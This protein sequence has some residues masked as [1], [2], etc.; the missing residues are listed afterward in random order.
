MAVAIPAALPERPFHWRDALRQWRRIQ[1]AH[2]QASRP[3]S[4]RRR[5]RCRDD[6]ARARN[7]LRSN[8]ARCPAGVAARA[9]TTRSD[10]RPTR[11]AAR[12]ARAALEDLPDDCAAVDLMVARLRPSRSTRSRTSIA[13]RRLRSERKDSRASTARP[14]RGRGNA[15]DERNRLCPPQPDT[16]PAPDRSLRRRL[17]LWWSLADTSLRTGLPSPCTSTRSCAS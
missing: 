17:Q 3:T 6:A 11:A 10:G 1:G 13:L 4:I 9:R 14:D 5:R 15:E 16:L 12:A 7:P 2:Q 8:R